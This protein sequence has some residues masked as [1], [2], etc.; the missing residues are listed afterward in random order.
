MLQNN[1]KEQSTILLQNL[2]PVKP[3]QKICFFNVDS[4]SSASALSL[5]LDFKFDE[6]LDLTVQQVKTENPIRTF[7]ISGEIFYQSPA[8]AEA[9]FAFCEF[10]QQQNTNFVGIHFNDQG[11]N[12]FRATTVIGTDNPNNGN[13][14]VVSNCNDN[15]GTYFRSVDVIAP[16]NIATTFTIAYDAGTRTVSGTIGGV[17]LNSMTLPNGLTFS[18]D[19][20]A[21][22]MPAC[23]P[24]TGNV[25][26]WVD[27][28]CPQINNN[29]II[30]PE[31]CNNGVDDDGDGFVDCND[32]DCVPDAPGAIQRN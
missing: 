30:T 25:S 19:A 12:T 29:P 14:S 8:S 16:A 15:Q 17:A 2:S 32:D 22:T 24:G 18:V 27:A 13:V 26:F 9:I 6:Q 1:L 7:S 3:G 28:V 5:S 23:L 20:F 21:L 4:G 11:S 10:G 31:V